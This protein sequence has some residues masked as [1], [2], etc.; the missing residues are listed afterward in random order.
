MARMANLGC[1]A[2][3]SIAV[4]IFNIAF[5]VIAL[6]E[7]NLAPQDILKSKPVK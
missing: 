1:M 6:K 3:L 4:V 2:A 5:W 7:F